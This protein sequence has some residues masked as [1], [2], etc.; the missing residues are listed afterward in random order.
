MCKTSFCLCHWNV[1]LL[2]LSTR[3]V[4]SVRLTV[5]NFHIMRTSIT[6]IHYLHFKFGST[7]TET[8]DNC[9]I[10]SYSNYLDSK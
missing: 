7:R 8:L 1:Y 9:S 4:V 2:I 6:I 10:V 3:N 5:F